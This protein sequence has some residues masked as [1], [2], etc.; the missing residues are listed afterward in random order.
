MF[1]VAVGV[2]CLFQAKRPHILTKR[3]EEFMQMKQCRGGGAGSAGDKVF[4]CPREG[5]N[6]VLT[7]TPGLRYHMRTHTADL[8]PYMCMKCNKHFKR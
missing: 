1:V 2:C 5:C 8:Q 6:K 4:M 3:M 7:S